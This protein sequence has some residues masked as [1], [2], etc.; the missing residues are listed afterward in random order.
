MTPVRG[1][2]DNTSAIQIGHQVSTVV[3]RGSGWSQHSDDDGSSRVTR[4]VRG[5]Q[6]SEQVSSPVGLKEEYTIDRESALSI[7]ICTGVV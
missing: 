2:I 3:K 4:E 6:V 5:S 7:S 1:I